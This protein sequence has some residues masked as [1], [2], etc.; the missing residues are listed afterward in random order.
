[1]EATAVREAG[2]DLAVGLDGLSLRAS[3]VHHGEELTVLQA[4][5][6]HR[7]RRHDPMDIADVEFEDTG[8]VTAPLPGKIVQVLVRPGAKVRKGE[9][10]LVMEAMKMEH[11]I[12]APADGTVAHVGFAEG[13][14][15]EEGAELIG[16]EA[17]D[18]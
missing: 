11:T 10:L 2:G 14:Q 8:C 9:V 13:E 16:F 1:M 3:V 6:N 18:A 7:L 17:E 12:A 5:R 4:G 15:V